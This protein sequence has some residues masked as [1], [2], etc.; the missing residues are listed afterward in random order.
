[1]VWG[2]IDLSGGARLEYEVQ[3]GMLHHWGSSSRPEKT[4]AGW[5]N[6]GLVIRII[7]WL[8]VACGVLIEESSNAH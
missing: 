2:W 4:V 1:M 6:R 5:R 8:L 7:F 3:L